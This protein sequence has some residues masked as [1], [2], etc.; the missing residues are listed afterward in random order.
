MNKK[1][2]FSV[3]CFTAVISSAFLSCVKKPEEEKTEPEETVYAVNAYR[4]SPG[5]LDNYLEFGGDVASVSAVDVLPDQMGK[6]SRILVNVGD[7]VQK[8]QVL[9][10]VD[11]SRPG[12]TFA[13]SP[14]KAPVSGRITS[15][16]PTVGTQVAQSMSIAKISNT[17]ELEIKVNVAE[18]FIS[19]IA[20]NQKAVLTFD[21]YPGEQFDAFVS[22]VSPVLDTTSRTMAIKIKIAKKDSRIKV[23]MYAR[24][25]LITESIKNALLVPA[26]AVIKRD[27]NPYVF[28]FAQEE[29]A[30][31]NTGKAS[32]VPVKQGITV[33]DRTEIAEGISAGNIII[34]KGQ[35]LL[36]D[37]S[38]VKIVSLSE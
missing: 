33:D 22:E 16:S 24:V 19:R 26:A 34:T 2:I 38:K 14:V 28:M 29:G 5:N 12:Y 1:K 15:F 20:L 35:S 18:R 27:G 3:I 25:K 8:E 31:E 11:A 21:A 13:A 30:D 9:A 4:T 23:G 7:M 6:V 37:G 36:N 32:L 17:D 10:Y